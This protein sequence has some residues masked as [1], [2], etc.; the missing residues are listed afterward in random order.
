MDDYVKQLEKR[1]AEQEEKIVKLG[2]SI[3]VY[4]KLC[5][6]NVKLG[7]NT[8]TVTWNN[9]STVA[10]IGQGRRLAYKKIWEV[11]WVEDF[12]VDLHKKTE[13]KITDAQLWQ[14]YT[15][16]KL[17]NVFRPLQQ[18]MMYVLINALDLT[19]IDYVVKVI[20]EKDNTFY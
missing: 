20:D 1:I 6:F 17:D 11:W 12:A 18:T 10:I 7:E 4:D 16:L 13:G 15:D 3:S 2:S 19:S 8:V 5:K 14:S 9:R